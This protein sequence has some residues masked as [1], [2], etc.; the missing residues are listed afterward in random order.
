MPRAGRG[1]GPRVEGASTPWGRGESLRPARLA[2]LALGI[3]EVSN[4]IVAL[5]RWQLTIGEN[6]TDP[7]M[8]E[9]CHMIGGTTRDAKKEP[10]VFGRDVLETLRLLAPISEA[11]LP[12][13]PANGS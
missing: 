5:W 10:V 7:H 9:A 4:R 13:R 12:G 1:G 3:V 2:G 6:A 11:A 8:H